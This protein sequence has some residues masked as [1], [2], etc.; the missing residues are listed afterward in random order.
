[1]NNQGVSQIV[2]AVLLIGI[3]VSAFSVIY[4]YAPNELYSV[5]GNE[6]INTKMIGANGGNKIILQHMGGDILEEY[7]ISLN[8]QITTGTD[9][10]I[11]ES[12]SFVFSNETLVIVKSHNNIIFSGTFIPYNK[13][14][15]PPENQSGDPTGVGFTKE[16]SPFCPDGSCQYVRASIYLNT[17]VAGYLKIFDADHNLIRYQ[18]NLN[19]Y[20]GGYYFHWGG[21]DDNAQYVN[22][23]FYYINYTTNPIEEGFCIGIIQANCSVVNYSPQ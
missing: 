7:T 2:G 23:G 5:F 8:D 15:T 9:W 1:M 19:A 13:T 14:S 11:G 22:D 18:C 6:R 10:K 20:A 21:K 17:S 4:L 12:K 3:A 16:F